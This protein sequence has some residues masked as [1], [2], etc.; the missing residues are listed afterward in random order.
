[1]MPRASTGGV[2][3]RVSTSRAHNSWNSAMPA[4]KQARW[5]PFLPVGGN[6]GEMDDRSA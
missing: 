5:H 6:D 2:V 4:K 1:M 3:V